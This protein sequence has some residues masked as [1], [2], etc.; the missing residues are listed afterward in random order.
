MHQNGIISHS[1]NIIIQGK[2][3]VIKTVRNKRTTEADT[4]AF[5]NAGAKVIEDIQ[6]K[7]SEKLDRKEWFILS[8]RLPQEMIKKLDQKRFNNGWASRN[9][10][11]LLALQKFLEEEN[12]NTV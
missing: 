3:M 9:S 12:V 8:L 10:C 5:I 6:V 4:E 7:K 2:Y 1:K 11:I